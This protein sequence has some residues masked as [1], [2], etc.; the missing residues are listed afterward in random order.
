MHGNYS[1]HPDTCDV[2]S[3]ARLNVWEEAV[4]GVAALQLRIKEKATFYYYYKALSQAS[5]TAALTN[6]TPPAKSKHQGSWINESS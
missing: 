4:D 5:S 6:G 1:N 3:L 2:E